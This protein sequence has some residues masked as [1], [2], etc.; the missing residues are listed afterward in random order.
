MDCGKRRTEV[1]DFP[2]YKGT[3]IRTWTWRDIKQALVGNTPADIKRI[4]YEFMLHDEDLRTQGPEDLEW[5]ISGTTLMNNYLWGDLVTEKP[6]WR[7]YEETDAYRRGC[8]SDA[9]NF[10]MAEYNTKDNENER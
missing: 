10:G 1:K 8:M 5:H 9:T 4:E 2:L 3:D 6:W 7:H